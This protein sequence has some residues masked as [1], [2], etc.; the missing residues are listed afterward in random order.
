MVAEQAA[1]IERLKNSVLRIQGIA[2]SARD[3]AITEGIEKQIKSAGVCALIVG[4]QEN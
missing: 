3:R 2:E 1:E 4:A